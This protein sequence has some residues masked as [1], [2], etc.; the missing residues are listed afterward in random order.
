[1]V[2]LLIDHLVPPNDLQRTCFRLHVAI[3]YRA[4]AIEIHPR[5]LATLGDLIQ[6][7][8]LL[9]RV[10]YPGV[11]ITPKLH[12]YLHL[13]TVLRRDGPAR[14]VCCLRYEAKHQRLT[15]LYSVS[16][17]MNQAKIICRREERLQAARFATIPGQRPPDLLNDTHFHGLAP[18]PA[19]HHLIGV[20]QPAFGGPP[21]PLTFCLRAT[22]DGTDFVAEKCV[23]RRVAQQPTYF[24]L[25][26]IVRAAQQTFFVG[27]LLHVLG[28]RDHL[29]LYEVAHTQ[30]F[31]A[32]E[33]QHCA[34]VH[35]IML[36]PHAHSL[37]LSD[38]TSDRTFF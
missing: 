18:V 26:A 17:H 16:N 28:F 19:G 30:N 29:Q 38:R 35:A 14:W 22:I 36:W 21:P 23:I 11:A 7:H 20:L 6:I 25:T 34:T 9:F 3:L 33:T 8:H 31:V 5:T 37:F 27:R 10:A 2:L 12:F 1:V 15:E 32:V 24:F 4:L 13:P